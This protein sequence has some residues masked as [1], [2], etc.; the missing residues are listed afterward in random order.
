MKHP[1][2]I[3]ILGTRGIPNQYGGFE[4]CAQYLA[5]GLAAKGHEVTVY[6]S[7][8]HPYTHKRWNGVSI[9]HQRDRE[10]KFGTFGQ[11]LY[12]LGCIRDARA[13]NFDV[14]IQL[15]Y[16]SSSVW[17]WLW[18]EN[19][20]HIVNMDGLEYNRSKYPYLVRQFLKLAEHMATFRADLLVADN[21]GIERYLASKYSK[22]IRLISYGAELPGKTDVGILSRFGL[23]PREY[24]LVIARLEPEN[25]IEE[26]VKAHKRSG[27][28]I[29]LLV[30]GSLQTSLARRLQ[31]S[32]S[33]HVRFAGSIYEKSLLDSLRKYTRLYFHGHSVGGT[34]PSLLEAMASECVICAHDNPFNREVLGDSACYFSTETDL[35]Q[36]IAQPPPKAEMEKWKAAN[37][38]K[39]KSV[40]RW[41]DIIDAYENACY[42]VG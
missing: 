14:I 33:N 23:Q 31:G 16:T 10:D 2:R 27:T 8:L 1:L 13:R 19:T 3:G 38:E 37:L 22:P 6:N 17:F 12:D 26:I 40:H 18:P 20:R 11:F 32:P 36:M 4:Q 34:N 15:G 35:R 9:I 28:D 7:S 24:D 39:L 41:N 29:P 25:H 42:E 5:E 21:P 30:I